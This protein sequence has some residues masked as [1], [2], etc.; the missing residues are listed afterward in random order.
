MVVVKCYRD[1]GSASLQSRL[2]DWVR[3]V[4]WSI[5]SDIGCVMMHFRLMRRG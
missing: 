4:G 1:R 2:K 5:E 3:D